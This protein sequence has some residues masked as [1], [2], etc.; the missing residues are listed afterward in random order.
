MHFFHTGQGLTRNNSERKK[1]LMDLRKQTQKPQISQDGMTI[2]LVFS[3][4]L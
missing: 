4:F 2:L 3:Q 1:L